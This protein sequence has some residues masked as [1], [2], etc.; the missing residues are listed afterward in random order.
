MLSRDHNILWLPESNGYPTPSILSL[1]IRTRFPG[2][3][4]LHRPLFC[5]PPILAAVVLTL[6]GRKQTY[7]A[8]L[9]VGTKSTVSQIR[10]EVPSRRQH[11]RSDNSC[12][13]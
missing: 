3:G 7:Y 2:A 8:R 9:F 1:K 5:E 4:Q 11:R 12:S 6:I 10:T 13:T